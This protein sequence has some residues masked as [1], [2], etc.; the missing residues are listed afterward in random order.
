MT[1]TKSSTPTI[2]DVAREA[3]VSVATVSRYL[4]QNGPISEEVAARLQQVMS[5]LNYVPHATAR[6]LATHKTHTIGL[7]MTDI[8]GDFFTPLLSGIEAVTGEAGFDLLIASTRQRERHKNFS[9][10]VGPHNTDGLLVFADS[11]DEAA[12]TRLYEQNF[13]LV[14]IHQTPPQGLAIPC[15]TVENKAASRN[16]VSHL[17]EKHHRRQIVLLRGPKKQE[18]SL[19]REMGYRQALET[20][21]IAYE[22]ALVADGEFDRRVAQASINRLL[23]AGVPFDGVFCGDDDAAI[24]VYKALSEAGKRIPGD[25]A[26]VGFDDQRM[27]PFLTPPLTTVRA[28]TEEVGRMATQQLINLIRG[29]PVEPLILLPTEIVIRRSCGCLNNDPSEFERR[30][31]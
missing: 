20:H 7:T 26:V 23:Q 11:L 30:N 27:A 4:N 13:P 5:E 12:L 19:W 17:I 28:P 3:G 10:P 31:P 15:V 16:L 18:D 14:M 24:G 22:P 25:V 1:K 6:S 8:S 29:Q 2:R 21:G 9:A